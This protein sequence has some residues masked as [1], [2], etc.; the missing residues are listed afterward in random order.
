MLD[1]EVHMNIQLAQSHVLTGPSLHSAEPVF[2]YI[3]AYYI[4]RSAG[5]FSFLSFV[6]YEY[7]NLLITVALSYGLISG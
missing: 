6:S 1:V 7:Y 5:K 2:V 3:S 4:Y